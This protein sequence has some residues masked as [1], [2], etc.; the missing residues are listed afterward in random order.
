MGTN[1]NTKTKKRAHN[2]VLQRNDKTKGIWKSDTL[3]LKNCW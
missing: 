2:Y 3:F 1:F